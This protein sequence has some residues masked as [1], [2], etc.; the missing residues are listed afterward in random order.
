MK[1]RHKPVQPTAVRRG[2][3]FVMLVILAIV[4]LGTYVSPLCS[5]PSPGPLPQGADMR[6]ED[7]YLVGMPDSV[8][9]QIIEYTGFT[10]SFNYK[11]GIP[12]YSVWELTPDRVYG[13]NPRNSRFRPDPKAYG[14]PDLSDYRNSG[15]DRGHMAPAGDMKWDTKAMTDSH[16][17]TNICPQSHDLNGGVWKSIEKLCRN[18]ALRDSLLVIVSGPVLTDRIT[19]FIGEGHVSVPSRFFKVV[20][21]PTVN[22]PRAIGFVAS[23]WDANVP[24]QD[25]VRTVDEIE[26]IT[27]LDFF[28]ALPDSLEEYVESRTSLGQWNSKSRKK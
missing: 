8:P 14:C 10:V 26:E 12:N 28:K 1:R 24:M 21:A 20:L 16:Y 17:L 4:L 2:W 27:G 11:H 9:S 22:P 18:W 3:N 15:Y 7:L 5:N 19:T 6:T 25:M 23:Q 13:I